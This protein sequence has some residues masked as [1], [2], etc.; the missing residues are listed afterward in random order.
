MFVIHTVIYIY[1]LWHIW[2][3]RS[4]SA[5]RL[6]RQIPG[7]GQR[8]DGRH[9]EDPSQHRVGQKQHGICRTMV[10]TTERSSERGCLIRTK[11]NETRHP[12]FHFEERTRWPLLGL[13]LN[14]DESLTFTNYCVSSVVY[15]IWLDKSERGY[16]IRTKRNSS[17]SF[18]LQKEPVSPLGL[19]LNSDESSTFTNYCV[20][21]AGYLIWF[22]LIWFDKINV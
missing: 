7:S 3:H 12:V 2:E 6:S 11:R 18:T 20:S 10:Y 5:G 17:S 4:V 13:F 19:F 14:S 15:L 8:Y 22:D 21:S 1:T 9:G 16:L